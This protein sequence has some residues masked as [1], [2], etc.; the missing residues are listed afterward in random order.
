LR[1]GQ[2]SYVGGDLN[3]TLLAFP[4]HPR[5]L[6][7][8]MKLSERGKWTIPQG[9]E[10][11]IDCYFDRAIR[12]RENDGTVRMV[13]ATY[14]SKRGKKEDAIK[15][16]EKAVELGSSG[17]NLDY[18]LGLAYFD[19]GKYDKA[20]EHAHRAY[21]RGF[22]LPGLKSK[23]VNVGKWRDPPPVAATG[24]EQNAE[25][26]EGSTVGAEEGAAAPAKPAGSN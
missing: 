10:Y 23:L 13:Y 19:V 15:Q 4:N 16:L 18:N 21:Q 11:T 20:L 12:F 24:A 1:G 5:A 26:K 25:A 7:A 3:Y 22:N 8:M 6:I 2:S 17:P 9:A 14:L